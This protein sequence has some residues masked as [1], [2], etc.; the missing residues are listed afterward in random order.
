MLGDD[1][2]LVHKGYHSPS[3]VQL[4]RPE[5]RLVPLPACLGRDS[6]IDNNEDQSSEECAIDPSA[7]RSGQEHETD[8]DEALGCVMWANQAFEDGMRWQSVFLKRRQIPVAVV[9]G[10]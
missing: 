6:K 8:I 3:T 5:L 10:P 7:L 1:A 9:L 2:C 4:L